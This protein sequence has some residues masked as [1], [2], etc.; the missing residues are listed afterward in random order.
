M[1]EVSDAFKA[2]WASKTWKSYRRDV[3]IRRRYWNGS[4]F[5][6]EDEF[7]TLRPAD[8]K[9]VSPIIQAVDSEFQSIF[10]ISEFT[11]EVASPNGEWMVSTGSPSFFA[12]DD[13]AA[14]GYEPV[15]SEVA[16][17][18]TLELADGSEEPATIF[19]GVLRKA[20]AM[21][22][23][24]LT[25]TLVVAS[26]A[27]LLERSDAENIFDAVTL[28]DCVP[29]T[30]DDSNMDFATTSKGVA[31]IE[32]FQV[33]GDSVPQGRDDALLQ[34]TSRDV[35]E[36]IPATIST[37]QPPEV[38]QT[39]KWSGR[40]WKQ[41]IKVEDFV[42][43][44]L[45]EAGIVERSISPVSYPIPLSAYKRVDSQVE[46]EAGT[47]QTLLDTTTEPGSIMN[48]W[49]LLD[50]FTTSVY[51][52]WQF[53]N[54]A[55]R[56]SVSGGRLKS[57]AGAGGSGGPL[58]MFPFTK[59]TG[60][61]SFKCE[62][63]A[64][65]LT[66]VCFFLES[67]NATDG[68]GNPTGQGYIL[69]VSRGSSPTP[70]T[71]T[72]YRHN[73]NW[74]IGA[75]RTTI[76]TVAVATSGDN[77]WSV[78]RDENGSFEVFKN[79]VSIGTVDDPTY[80]TAAYFGWETGVA[81]DVYFDDLFWSPL[82]IGDETPDIS[83]S[84][85]EGIFDLLEAPP[86][87]LAL[88]RLQEL[89]GGA[90]TF[91]TAGADE[92]PMSPGNP[93]TFD[94]LVEVEAVTRQMLS[95]AKR[96]LKVQATMTPK[97]P[98]S[99]DEPTILR[100]LQANYSTQDLF[101]TV[102]NLSGLDGWAALERYVAPTG[103]A[104]GFK[105][106]GTFFL[107]SKTAPEAAAADLTQENCLI[108]LLEFDPGD[109]RIKNVGRV[110]YNGYVAEFDGADAGEAEPTSEQRFGRIAGN[111]TL[112]DVLYANDVSLGEARAAAIYYA[113]Y[114]RARRWRFRCWLVPWL[115]LLDRVNVTFLRDRYAASPVFGDK[116]M[117]SE[118]RRRMAVW[119]AP[120]SPV[121]VSGQL[122][123]VLGWTPDVDQLGQGILYVEEV[124]DD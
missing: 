13:T 1:I 93:G 48:R 46:W 107:R 124:L 75:N 68:F 66:V 60:T 43:A 86:S 70:D 14:A 121:F 109:D 61:W 62:I 69:A 110:R 29:P 7:T 17:D 73:G 33:N 10:L 39:A 51:Q 119:G 47:T 105:A 2:A 106:D 5:V 21:N 35:G 6:L 99:P 98:S 53:I 77:R 103:Y 18:V 42:E 4:D 114:R 30:G 81:A 19:T 111:E 108:E 76:L 112:D 97:A 67:S 56:W 87:L 84:V 3:R 71:V 64:A 37:T 50:P 65:G 40:L 59:N 82:L 120:D 16:V 22:S 9:R 90:T 34:Y 11:I 38:G 54:L 101:I 23:N 96:F 115:E 31:A 88:D 78:T 41:D 25:A 94:A 117:D 28:E 12:I 122:C 91:K 74:A 45:D 55:G 92:D 123:T 49:R 24:D 52:A 95:T 57:A 116:L 100:L 15:S 102:A 83:D 32:D 63:T 44:V 36:D 79:G 58:A 80:S 104:M 85:W 118:P 113:G 72:L 27:L 20:P 89:N 26:R 8:V